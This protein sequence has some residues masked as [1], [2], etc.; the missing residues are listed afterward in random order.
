MYKS[1]NSLYNAASCTTSKRET[2]WLDRQRCSSSSAPKAMWYPPQLD[3][4]PGMHTRCECICLAVL[5]L[6]YTS[7]VY[8]VQEPPN[9]HQDRKK[10]KDR[11]S[12]L[13]S[14]ASSW[15]RGW[16]DFSSHTGTRRMRD[17][18]WV[19]KAASGVAWTG[20][21]AR[22]PVHPR[23]TKL[24]SWAVHVCYKVLRTPP[25]LQLIGH[26]RTRIWAISTRNSRKVILSVSIKPSRRLS[27]VFSCL[28]VV[29]WATN[30]FLG[31]CDLVASI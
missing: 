31:K 15:T 26:S 23:D 2:K 28:C 10:K 6:T 30:I 9:L 3:R 4:D 5:L 16:A 19:E 17:A 18:G 21:R 29:G 14:L 24:K 13:D 12:L 22:I 25:S 20:G 11:S 8:G 27:R 1:R 7:T